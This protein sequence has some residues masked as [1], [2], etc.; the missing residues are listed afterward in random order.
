[1]RS[2]IRA[3]LVIASLA[4]LGGCSTQFIDGDAFLFIPSGAAAENQGSIGILGTMP[5]SAGKVR[6]KVD[7]RALAY[8][9]GLGGFQY[10]ELVGGSE[11]GIIFGQPVGFTTIELVDTRGVTVVPALQLEVRMARRRRTGSTVRRRFWWA[12]S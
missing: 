11:N 12:R 1:M 6:I 8:N 3:V 10:G 9:D 4:A 2:P 5:A 7:G